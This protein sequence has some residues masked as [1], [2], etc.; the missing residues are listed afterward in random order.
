MADE[1]DV[2]RRL[3]HPLSAVRQTVDEISVEDGVQEVA[4]L[5]PLSP[6]I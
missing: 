6:V 4:L 3:T 5:Q 1:H 2:A